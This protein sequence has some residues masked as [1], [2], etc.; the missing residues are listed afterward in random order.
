[1]ITGNN[2]RVIKP[3]ANKDKSVQVLRSKEKAEVFTP[4]WV[5]NAQNNL[6]DNAWFGKEVKRFNTEKN[7]SWKTN[8]YKVKFPKHKTWKEY[9]TANRMEISCGEAPY[10]TSRYGMVSGKYIAVKQRIGLLD[11]KLRIVSENTETQKE[12][13][14]WAEKALHS[15]YGFEWQGDNILLAREK[16]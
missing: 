3:R 5:C 1:M 4:A 10:L 9:V 13:K 16:P 8:Y 11:R 15:I 6:V 2:E 12:W 14:L 7:C